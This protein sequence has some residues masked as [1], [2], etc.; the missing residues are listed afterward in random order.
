MMGARIA[1][2]HHILIFIAGFALCPR[3]SD[4]VA[5]ACLGEAGDFAL[6]KVF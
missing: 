6:S 1:G 3:L 5:I 2:W 4:C